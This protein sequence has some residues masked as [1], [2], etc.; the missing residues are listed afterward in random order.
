MCPVDAVAQSDSTG[1]ECI[2]RKFF[3]P[4]ASSRGRRIESSASE[5][6]VDPDCTPR[7]CGFIRRF[8]IPVI[9][10]I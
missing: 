2:Y 8:T 6:P 7:F 5:A 9:E 3:V 10:P 4:S 1:T